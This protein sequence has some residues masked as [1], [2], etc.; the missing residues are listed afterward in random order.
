MATLSK[1]LLILQV[2]G[3]FSKIIVGNAWYSSKS[4]PSET[5]LSTYMLESMTFK[6]L[7]N[8]KMLP[9]LTMNELLISV[10][11]KPESKYVHHFAYKYVIN[12]FV[13]CCTLKSV[14]EDSNLF[15]HPDS[16]SGTCSN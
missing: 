3:E 10:Q 2:K 12:L 7:L 5:L 16:K 11:D 9:L 15:S 6:E 8:S 1:T 14:T 13:H 4:Y